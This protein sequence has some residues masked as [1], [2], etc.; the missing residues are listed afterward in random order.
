M[1]L[2]GV[3]LVLSALKGEGAKCVSNPMQYGLEQIEAKYK[4]PASCTCSLWDSRIK[5]F[6][7]TSNSTLSFT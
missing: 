7:I 1:F 4:I 5:P 2:I 3:L 6:I